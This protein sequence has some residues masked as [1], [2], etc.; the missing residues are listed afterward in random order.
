MQNTHLNISDTP[1]LR[2]SRC[3]LLSKKRKR[4]TN[5][6]FR[7]LFAIFLRIETE[8][9]TIVYRRDDEGMTKA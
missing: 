6:S 1:K 3:S 9:A 4:K 2:K 8:Y 5:I 7:I